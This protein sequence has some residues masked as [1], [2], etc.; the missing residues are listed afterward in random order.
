MSTHAEKE[1]IERMLEAFVY[2]AQCCSHK[3][4]VYNALKIFYLADKLHMEKH[5]R[6]IFDDRYAALPKGPVPSE[7]Y[8]LIKAIKLEK[9]LPFDLK[10]SVSYGKDHELSA[11]KEFD[12]SLFSDSD[13]MCID[14]VIETS[15][16]A[17]LG[18]LSHDQA[19]ENCIKHKLHFMPNKEIIGALKNAESLLNL[20]E[21]RFL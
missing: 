8:D 18:D 1:R 15:K 11:I 20:Q 7:A 4:N 12:D 16:T 5:G 3:P 14:E 2:I 17:D 9:E 21:N 10:P 13:L 6:F 19:W